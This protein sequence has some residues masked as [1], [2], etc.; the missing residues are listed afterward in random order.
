MTSTSSIITKSLQPNI[1]FE[2][3]EEWVGATYSFLRSK[4]GMVYVSKFYPNQREF[5]KVFVG[6]VMNANKEKLY[7]EAIRNLY[8]KLDFIELKILKKN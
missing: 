4:T 2:E 8:K 7:V 6:S 1:E 3:D 5:S